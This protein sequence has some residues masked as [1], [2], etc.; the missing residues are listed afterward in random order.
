MLSMFFLVVSSCDQCNAEKPIA[1]PQLAPWRCSVTLAEAK[2]A[3]NHHMDQ[4][5]DDSSESSFELRCGY[6]ENGADNC[7][8]A[9]DHDRGQKPAISGRRLHW[10]SFFEI[11][12]VDFFKFLQCFV[13]ISPGFLCN[14]ARKPP[15]TCGEI[16]PISGW[17]KERR[18][19]PRT[20]H[21]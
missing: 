15:P 20:I 16:C 8:D 21:E 4:L 10:I 14:L 18:Y 1:A 19:S 11:S 3:P 2:S 5:S 9:F 13:F 7:Q 17:R 6:P 12:L